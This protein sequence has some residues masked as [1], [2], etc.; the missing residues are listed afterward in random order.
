MQRIETFLNEEEVDEQ[1]STLK[2]EAEGRQHH[3][4]FDETE[5]FG[6]RNASF[7][8]NAVLEDESSSQKT[9][10]KDG[11]SNGNSQSTTG[12]NTD[13]DPTSTEGTSGVDRKFE[14]RDL[15]VVFPHGELT[16]VTGPT[17]SGKTALLVCIGL[18]LCARICSNVV[19]T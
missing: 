3:E 11:K 8:W 19:S 5:K 14:L 2:R 4:V 7:T 6:F 10:P 1:V 16:V 13:L 17:A 15:N 18:M 9:K 12:V